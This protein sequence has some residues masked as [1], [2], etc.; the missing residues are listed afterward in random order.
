[1]AIGVFDRYVAPLYSPEGREEFHHYAGVEALLERHNQGHITLVAECGL[2]LVGMLQ[3]RKWHH[4]NMLFVAAGH[5]RQG[6]GRTLLARAVDLVR[7]H[8][9]AATYLTVNASPNAVEAYRRFRFEAWELEQ[10]V[11]GIRC[12][13]MRLNLRPG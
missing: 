10:I 6:I 9:P 5:Q 11:N 13:P 8:D 3:L 7:Q 4:V 1:L 2:E 12:I